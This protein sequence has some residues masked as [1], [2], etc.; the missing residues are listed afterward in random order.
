MT[1]L[2][3]E[4]ERRGLAFA[5]YA[6][7]C[8][9][10]VSSKAAG[11]RVMGSVKDFLERRLRLKVNEAKSAVARPW[12]RKF[13]GYSV[14]AQ[15][16]TRLRIAVPSLG[17][18]TARVKALMRPGKGCSLS[19]TI[20]RLNP[21][22]R[23]WINYFRLTQSRRPLEELDA[24]VRRHLRRLLWKQWKRPQTRAVVE[25][26]G[27]AYGASSATEVLHTHGAGQPGGHPPGSPACHMNRRMRNRTYG[28]VR[29]R[30]E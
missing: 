23:G 16:E 17:R 25:R 21:L 5:R 29:G 18:L 26:R 12:E 20:E 24:W 14:T 7:D 19:R 8:N 27:A 4:L 10:Y 13:L 9:I 1:D 6:D 22:L 11:E 2:D 28:S 15:R 3:Q 30:P